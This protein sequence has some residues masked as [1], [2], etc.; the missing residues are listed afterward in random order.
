MGDLDDAIREHLELK[1]MRG[2]DPNE[3][4]RLE[5]EALGPIE[6]GRSARSGGGAMLAEHPE[7][8]S[9]LAEHE[10]YVTAGHEAALEH[11]Y[12]EHHDAPI[13]HGYVEHH[14]LPT[15]GH[16]AA[17]HV[18]QGYDSA[19]V[20]GATEVHHAQPVAASGDVHAAPHAADLGD[21]T[22]EFRLED[23]GTWVDPS[24]PH[25]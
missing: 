20:E 25:E 14:D 22:Q 10:E 21:E 6:R 19:Q 5:A 4:A 2:A 16:V 1:R 23:D 18:A 15:D 8:A 3:V 12:E 24:S 13:A 7:P 9:L 17:H 11:G